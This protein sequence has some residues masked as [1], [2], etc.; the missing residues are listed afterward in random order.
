MSDDRISRRRLLAGIGAVAVAVPLSACD[1][2]SRSPWFR[3]V[4]DTDDDISKA[5]QRFFLKPTSMAREFAET[6]ISKA[7][8]A[9][10]STDPDEP[11]YRTLAANNF[12]DYKLRI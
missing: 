10:G 3:P 9:N 7:F 6:D 11:E 1:Q 8:R 4:L 2:L 12:A 5:V